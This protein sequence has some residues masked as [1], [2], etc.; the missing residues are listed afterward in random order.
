[1][2]LKETRCTDVCYIHLA[3]G[4]LPCV[5]FCTIDILISGENT[6]GSKRNMHHRVELRL[7]FRL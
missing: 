4:V 5:Q 6:V 2:N 3:Q 7:F 1:M